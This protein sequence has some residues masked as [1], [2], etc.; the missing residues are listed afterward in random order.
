MKNC[1]NWSKTMI[2][3]HMS[4]KTMR[5]CHR[6]SQ[7]IIECH[8][9]S[10]CTRECHRSSQA[11]RDCHRLSQTIR[12]YHRLSKAIRDCHTPSVTV[13][14]RY[15]HQTL[16]QVA[17]LTPHNFPWLLLAPPLSPRNIMTLSNF[18]S[19]FLKQWNHTSLHNMLFKM[20]CW[21]REWRGYTAFPG[22]K[23]MTKSNH[24]FLYN[25]SCKS[26]KKNLFK[27][28]LVASRAYEG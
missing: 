1:H 9:L 23:T 15:R 10:Q 22:S 6:S 14:G 5:D 24:M 3:R 20:C 18:S 11:I 25:V 4:S 28:A 17:P 12:H 13:I 27:I 2:Y 19:L 7:A 21:P 8:R 16:S 26:L